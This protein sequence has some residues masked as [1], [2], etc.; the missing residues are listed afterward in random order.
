M[1]LVITSLIQLPALEVHDIKV[2]TEGSTQDDTTN[3]YLYNLPIDDKTLTTLQQE[4][5]FCK[6]HIKTNRKG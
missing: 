3:D 4:D 5:E 6:K 2:S 1:S